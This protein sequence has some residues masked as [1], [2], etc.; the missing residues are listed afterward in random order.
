MKSYLN[1]KTLTLIIAIFFIGAGFVSVS[2]SAKYSRKANEKTIDINYAENIAKNFLLNLEKSDYYSIDDGFSLKDD[3]NGV[4]CYILNLQPKGYIIV[5]SNFQLKPVLAY[6]F[7]SEKINQNDNNFFIELLKTDINLRLENINRIPSDIINDRIKEWSLLK[8]TG[9]PQSIYGFFEQWPPEGSTSTEGW[10]ETQWSQQKPFKNFCPMDG[11]K[12][13]VAG[14]PAV[15]M[16]QIL[17]FHKEL[18]NTRFSD[19]DDYLHNYGNFF[20][21]DDDHDEYDFPSFPEL[22][23]Y[24]STLENHFE[25]NISLTDDDKAAL[26]FACGIAAK[27]VYTGQV[28]GTFG[29][30]QAFNAYNRFGFVTVDLLDEND[31]DL[32]DRIIEN[33]KNAY[34]VHLALVTP[35]WDTGHNMIIDGYNTDNFYHINFGWGGAYDGWY[36][37]PDEDFPYG[38]TVVE[39]AI[40]DIMNDNLGSDLD[41]EGSLIWKNVPAGSTL[42]GS[43][44][45]KNIGEPESI[46]NWEIVAYPDWG[47]WSFSQTE[48]NDLRPEDDP[49]TVDVTVIAPDEKNKEFLGGIKISNRD[50]DGDIF[51]VPIT[52]ST[53]KNKNLFFSDFIH[54]FHQLF[55]FISN[56]CSQV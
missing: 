56:M 34:P 32:F 26:T 6:S 10:V 18:F 4:L 24:L 16:A 29:V 1:S 27:Q 37:L 20:T 46:L 55:L 7:N 41:C 53:L 14:C 15:A 3:T 44:K 22:N 52:V 42:E 54:R 30:N 40:I 5:N 33:I 36:N 11:D 2:Y 23:N 31:V 19:D 12:R 8:N 38:L 47:T 50:S 51:Y 35:Q 39:G 45:V 13:S 48:G 49:I 9:Y 17:N 25:E 21:I 43:F 28:S